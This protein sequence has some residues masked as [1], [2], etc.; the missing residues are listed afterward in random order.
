[1]QPIPRRYIRPLLALAGLAVTAAVYLISGRER[2]SAALREGT[3]AFSITY[4]VIVLLCLFFLFEHLRRVQLWLAVLTGAT[5]GYLAGIISYFT[6]VFV[7]PD[8]A[9]RLFNSIST[10]GLP[11][12]LI[13]LWIPIVLL[14]W[15]WSAVGFL[16]V[17][18]LSKRVD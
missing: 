5:V 14:C 15:T 16:I 7:M 17:S 11:S 3:T 9:A 8:G 2:V 18:G 1:M 10:M 13:V 12:L 4:M 6:A